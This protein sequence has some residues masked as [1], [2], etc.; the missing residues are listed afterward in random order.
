MVVPAD[1]VRRHA[2]GMLWSF[3]PMAMPALLLERVHHALG[4]TFLL[5][6]E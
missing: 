1:P 2:V 4:H 6:K 5:W 3:K